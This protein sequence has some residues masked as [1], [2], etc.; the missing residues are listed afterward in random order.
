MSEEKKLLYKKT[1]LL[2]VP[3]MIQQGITNAVGLVDN[4]MV[5]S[6]GEE[7]ITAVSIAGQLMFVFN[8]AIFGALSGPGIY[9]AQ[10]YGNGDTEG[11]RG[12]L[13]DQMN[14]EKKI[15][16]SAFDVGMAWA[17]AIVPFAN[18]KISEIVEI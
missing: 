4:L 3:I 12:E 10:Y 11:V 8:L 17:T 13:K 16:M 2:A 18:C 14:G 6:L 15:L 7:A 1:L 5:G 9:G